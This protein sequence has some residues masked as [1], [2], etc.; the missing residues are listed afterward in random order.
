[1][2]RKLQATGKSD[3]TQESYLRA[4]GQIVDHFQTGP[5]EIYE[6][7]LEDYF[8]GDLVRALITYERAESG[9][10]MLTI[11]PFSPMDPGTTY[12]VHISKNVLAQTGNPN[13]TI[14]KY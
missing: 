6:K 1:M 2:T 5:E 7:Q 14:K 4:M 13:V 12:Y 3:R 8:L 10:P 9:V 11:R